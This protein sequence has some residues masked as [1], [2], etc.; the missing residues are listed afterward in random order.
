[1][2]D[3]K[4]TTIKNRLKVLGKRATTVAKYGALAATLVAG[5]PKDAKAQGYMM[6]PGQPMSFEGQVGYG[7]G[8]VQRPEFF[9][10]GVHG[11]QRG[12][13]GYFYDQGGN[14]GGRRGRVRRGRRNGPD[15]GYGHPGRGPGGGYAPRPRASSRG[16]YAPR[17][18]RSFDRRGPGG[19]RGFRG[20]P[21]GARARSGIRGR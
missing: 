11:G 6:A 12:P 2:T 17:P 19:N 3:N 5:A 18:G 10:S 13:G 14:P 15:N 1:M 4:K 8:Y 7:G 9:G 16:G 20:G 21:G